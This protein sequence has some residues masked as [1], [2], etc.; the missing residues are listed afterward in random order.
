MKFFQIV[1]IG[2]IESY[3]QESVKILAKGHCKNY[4]STRNI[5]IVCYIG[6][7]YNKVFIMSKLLLLFLTLATTAAQAES[8]LAVE[9]NLVK[10]SYQKPD[11]S[12]GVGKAGTMVFK[13]ANLINNGIV[14]NISNINN[15][16]DSQIFVRPTFLGFSTQFGNF[17]V[18]IEETSIL[19]T[20]KST[21]LENSK[22]ILDDNQLNFSG[23]SFTFADN[24]ANVK[25]L[26]FRLYCQK[27]L[28]MDDTGI[29]ASPEI[30]KSCLNFMTLN[31]TFE[32]SKELASLDY[33]TYNKENF[34][35][36]TQF[37]AKV[38]TF[39]FR[40]DQISGNLP[41]FK[42][43][44]KNDSGI[45]SITTNGLSFVCGKNPALETL[46]SAKLIKTCLNKLN[47][48]PFKATLEDTK[49]K[50]HF[51]LDFKKLG[52]KDRVLTTSINHITLRDSAATSTT[53]LHDVNVKCRK[54]TES[55]LLEVTNVLRDCISF[56]QVSIG[57]VF[58]ESKVSNKEDSSNKNISIT[59]NGGAMTIQAEVKFLGM[60]KKVSLYGK[61]SI[62]E[63]NKKIIASITDT[64][65]PFGINSVKLVMYF[66]KKDLVS[67]DI[68]INNN[69][70]TMAL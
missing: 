2:L 4:R 64:K 31:G 18:T 33:E 35:E 10:L 20:I 43:I 36:K 17:G 24:D 60:T 40:T 5:V 67:K 37:Q 26:N 19:N 15:L 25:L 8:K 48:E 69:V 16:F 63:K 41:S 68:Q 55:D 70:I 39:D 50:T 21:E 66:L 14:L 56:G 30:V 45:Y 9:L 46:D 51:F 54:E 34:K 58:S 65:L 3:D 52:I 28:L 7:K 57:E 42:S 6:F 53:Y 13:T 49:E 47:V 61:V 62:D 29:T 23:K 22:F 11:Q 38:K 44:T 12:G 32:D 59:I 1:V 27:P